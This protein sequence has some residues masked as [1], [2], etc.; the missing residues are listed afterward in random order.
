VRR[1]RRPDRRPGFGKRD[2][3]TWIEATG[4]VVRLLAD[5]CGGNDRVGERHQRIIVD[6]AG[7]QT[8]LVAHNTDVAERVPVGIG[9]RLTLRGFYEWNEFGGLVHWTHHDPM[10]VEEGGYLIHRKRTYC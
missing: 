10:G 8:L 2:D 4:R 6:V 9:D 7:G 1:R 5:D 3:G